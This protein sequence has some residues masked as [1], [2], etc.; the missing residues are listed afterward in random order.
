VTI[1]E[2][3]RAGVPSRWGALRSTDASPLRLVPGV[4]RGTGHAP[5]GLTVRR[6]GRPSPWPSGEG[7]GA[8][9]TSCR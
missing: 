4:G 8:T 3:D 2:P 9:C 6:R 1:A 7:T 5:P